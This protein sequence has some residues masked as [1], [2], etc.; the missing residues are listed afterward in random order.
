[1]TAVEH[2]AIRPPPLPRGRTSSLKKWAVRALIVL[3]ALLVLVGLFYAFENYR[4][5][6]AWKIYAREAKQA[7]HKIEL[8]EFTPAPVSD[9]DNIFKAPHIREWFAAGDQNDF[10]KRLNSFSPNSGASV[11][12]EVTLTSPETVVAPGNADL[13]LRYKHHMLTFASTSKSLSNDTP[14]NEVIPL[15]QFEQVPLSVGIK[16]LA[17]QFSLQYVFDSQSLNS[18]NGSEPV[19]SLRWNGLTAMEAL[20][21]LLELYNLQ[22]TGDP[23]TEIARIAAK[24]NPGLPSIYSASDLREQAKILFKRA[25]ESVTNAAPDRCAKGVTGL[26]FVAQP[27]PSPK[28]VRILVQVEK[29]PGLTEIERL[30]DS[31]II[32]SVYPGNYQLRAELAGTKSYRLSV[33]SQTCPAADYLR[34]SDQFETEF[35][36]LHS[37]LERPFARLDRDY[38]SPFALHVPNI[39]SVRILAQVLAQRTQCHLLLNQPDAALRDLTLLHEIRRILVTQPAT[40][41]SAMM[42]VS[43]VGLYI[44]TFN[45]G[46]RLEVWRTSDLAEIQRQLKEINLLPLL[47]EAFE[48]GQA[49][50]CRTFEIGTAAQIDSSFF[51]EAKTNDWQK[52]DSP[53]YRF[54]AVAPRGW[55]YLNMTTLAKADQKQME[56]FDL[57]RGLIFPQKQ[58]EHSRSIQEVANNHSFRNVLASK[59]ARYGVRGTQ[60]TARNQT[61]VNEAIA[62]CALERYRADYSAYPSSLAALAPSYLENIPCDVFG[63]APLKYYR[64]I[65]GN[66]L[67]YSV[68]WNETDD[69][70]EAVLNEY[71]Q[72]SMDKG[73][74]VWQLAGN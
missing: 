38:E 17:T 16:N 11:V 43:I 33:H 50:Q 3:P 23:R 47:A 32:D 25:Q 61:L 65:N 4:G 39:T 35:G 64:A 29:Q 63:G 71:G 34:W 66:F 18:G 73:D 59:A 40:L 14:S 27:P 7:G 49:T 41:V 12:A 54:C 60:I 69:G 5:R 9:T 68:G 8:K 44:D 26:R 45:D 1:M 74:W 42:H 28:P 20:V 30:I 21:E 15:I 48:Y 56:V 57:S 19:V 53:V 52:F 55:R 51:T 62:V 31:T 22:I 58:E 2:A 24:S 67:L 13:V 36:Q 46:I 10:R 6:R 72:P 70:G 37:A